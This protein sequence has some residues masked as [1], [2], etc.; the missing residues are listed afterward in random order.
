MEE[1]LLFKGHLLGPLP[2]T[3]MF[4]SDQVKNAVDHQKGDHTLLVQVEPIG[5]AF[6]CV[7]GNDQISQKLRAKT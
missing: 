6:G 1:F 5:L 3:L 2:W 4:I 7:H